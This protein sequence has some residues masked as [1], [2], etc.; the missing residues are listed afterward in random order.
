MGLVAAALAAPGAARA[1]D[2]EQAR[3]EG[4]FSLVVE[5][6]SLSSGAD[7][8]YT[9]GVRLAY[10]Q[11]T[12]DIPSWL[13]GGED[14]IANFTDARP[15]FWGVS[16]GQSI[17]TP[18]NIAANPAPPDEHPYAGYLYGQILL[19]TIQNRPDGMFPRF[20]DLYELEFG[21][22]GPSA[23]GQQAQQGIHEFL[24]APD[25]QGWDSQL[26]DEFVFALSYERRWSSLRYFADITPGGLEIVVSPSLGATLGTLRTEA[27]AGV[28]AQIGYQILNNYEIGPPRVRP[29]LSGAGYFEHRDFSWSLFAGV[30]AR[31]VARNIFLDG[32]T[33]RDSARVDRIPGV[34]DGQVG[35]TLQM[36]DARLAYTYVVRTDEFE[37]QTAAQDFGT[38]ALQLRF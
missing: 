37:T 23:L 25:P 34:V 38:L 24:G 18:E 28:T 31:A 4:V 13:S 27:R 26:H 36:G 33:Y 35:F 3:Q 30:Q 20:S 5:N 29:A 12:G 1:Q 6:D 10:V 16:I 21:M 11:P 14:F 15:A 8:N 32:N 7:R 2:V 22:I 19:A 9:S 17:F